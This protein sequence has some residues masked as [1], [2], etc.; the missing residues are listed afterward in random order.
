MVIIHGKTKPVWGS[1]VL[2]GEVTQIV[3]LSKG[4]ACVCSMCMGGKGAG[5]IWFRYGSSVCKY[6]ETRK[7]TKEKENGP[8]Y[9]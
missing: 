5:S 8:L 7:D 9:R 2:R 1:E 3:T 6:L 4:C